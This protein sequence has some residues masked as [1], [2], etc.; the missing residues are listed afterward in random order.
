MMT[1]IM[2]LVSSD[3]FVMP[4]NSSAQLPPR[5]SFVYF[6]AHGF[7][8]EEEKMRSIF[9]AKGPGEL[10]SNSPGSLTFWKGPLYYV[11]LV[12]SFSFLRNPRQF[13]PAETISWAMC[14]IRVGSP[15]QAMVFGFYIPVGPATKDQLERPFLLYQAIFL[16]DFP[17]L[18]CSFAV[19]MRG[20]SA[21][22]QTSCMGPSVLNSSYFFSVMDLNY[23]ALYTNVSIKN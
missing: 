13:W 3:H 14:L 20:F 9:Y 21:S 19:L 6:G 1:S 5:N 11:A 17:F 2:F 7:R 10:F 18:L 12:G 4:S 23:I 22:V 16:F 15:V 8:P